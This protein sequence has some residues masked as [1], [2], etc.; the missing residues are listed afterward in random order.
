MG[1]VAECSLAIVRGRL[2]IA[3]AIFYGLNGIQNRNFKRL[4]FYDRVQISKSLLEKAAAAG[5]TTFGGA[6]N[7]MYN[8]GVAHLYG[9]VWRGSPRR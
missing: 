9:Q 4:D 1:L 6:D 3:E 2:V 8:L 7:A 5:S